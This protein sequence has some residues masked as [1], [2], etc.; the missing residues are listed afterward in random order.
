MSE[1]PA[2]PTT[3]PTPREAV[4]AMR[5]HA[6]SERNKRLAKVLAA[7]NADASLKGLWYM[8]Q[9]NA[10]RLDMNDHSWVHLQIVLNRALHLFRLLRRRGV[11]SAM[12]ET[13]AM[14]ADDAEVVI[15]GGCLMHD[16]GMSIHRTDHESYSLFLA[17]AHMDRLLGG[18]YEEPERTVVASEIL[19]AIIGHRSGGRPLTLEAGV[20]RVADALDMEH[21]R[22]R[23]AYETR[24]P[25]IHAI[26]AAAIDEVKMVPGESRAVRVEIQMNNTAGVFQVDELLAN[27][28]RGSGLEDHVEVVARIDSEHE[29]RLLRVY[30]I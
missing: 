4:E 2:A 11:R 26:S 17:E 30:E 19:H 18:V 3:P 8:Q 13:H 20:V 12:E 29:K 15:A 6:P 27:K 24:L 23:V 7:A 9:V 22:S 1:Q 14:S 16:L 25:S 21:G 28:L 5:I 10:D